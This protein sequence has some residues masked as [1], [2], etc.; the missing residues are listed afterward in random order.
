MCKPAGKCLN[1]TMVGTEPLEEVLTTAQISFCPSLLPPASPPPLSFPKAGRGNWTG[2]TKQIKWQ[3]L[4]SAYHMT[5][6]R[7]QNSDNKPLRL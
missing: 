3:T 7:E 4:L 2:T 6:M 5:D 1:S